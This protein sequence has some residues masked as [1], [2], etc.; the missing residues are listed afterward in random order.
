MHAMRAQT[1]FEAE[2]RIAGEHRRLPAAEMPAQHG[3]ELGMDRARRRHVAEP[4]T[5]GRVGAEQT[6]RCAVGTRLG[7]RPRLEPRDLR[8]AGMRRVETRLA[9]ER[10]VEVTP[11]QDDTL[12]T[13]TLETRSGA[14]LGRIHQGLPQR[15]VV[16]EPSQETEIAPTV[17]GRETRGHA[18]GLD[19][20]R[21]RAA[22][23]V[24]EGRA[25]GGERGPARAQQHAGGDVLAQRRLAGIAAPA[26]PVQA[27]A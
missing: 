7:E 6:D 10:R 18:R 13:A 12:R 21:P 22:H 17:V 3:T 4:Q 14:H 27:L 11:A 1:E 20:Q 26:A 25:L 5:P 2:R 8:D 15:R 19:H 23:R 16:T 9:D 24:E